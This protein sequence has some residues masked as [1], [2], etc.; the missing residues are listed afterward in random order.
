MNDFDYDNL[1]FSFRRLDGINLSN[2]VL[3]ALDSLKSSQLI[4]EFNDAIFQNN[5][6]LL[7]RIVEV[8]DLSLYGQE[9]SDILSNI[10]HAEAQNTLQERLTKYNQPISKYTTLCNLAYATSAIAWSCMPAWNNFPLEGALL[11]DTKTTA[12]L[13]IMQGI[14]VATKLA[15]I[16]DDNGPILDIHGE[17]ISTPEQFAL[18]IPRVQRMTLNKEEITFYSPIDAARKLYH[19]FGIKGAERVMNLCSQA[20]LATS[21]CLAL[22]HHKFFLSNEGGMIFDIETGVEVSIAIK[23]IGNIFD[24]V[25]SKKLTQGYVILKHTVQVPY[26]LLISD[27]FQELTPDKFQA[28]DSISILLPYTQ[29]KC[30]LEKF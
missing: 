23:A 12:S 25:D 20:T 11:C 14:G 8:V 3:A 4:S 19:T 28:Q 15:L 27:E 9:I 10:D 24:V 26:K 17:S 22:E 1:N 30:L 5:K 21:T 6:D 16:A 2:G 29:A 7:K 13:E 18:D